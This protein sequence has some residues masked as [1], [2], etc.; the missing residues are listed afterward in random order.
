MT[1][2]SAKEGAELAE[3]GKASRAFLLGPETPKKWRPT[4]NFDA[5]P[6][7]KSLHAIS[8]EFF[9]L[10]AHPVIL[11]SVRA[12]LGNDILVWGVSVLKRQP[13]QVHRWHIDVEHIAWKG[14]S[15]FVGLS[16][17]RPHQSSLKFI[18]GSH[19]FRRGPNY[20]L[21]EGDDVILAQARGADP[22]CAMDYPAMGDGDFIMFD[23][24]MWHA[25]HN[26][27]SET[28]YASIIQYTSPSETVAVP[29]TWNDPIMWANHKPP[30]ILASG[31]DE[32]GRNVLIDRPVHS[33]VKK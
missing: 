21:G 14:V 19:R 9:N 27:T 2:L 26:S 23:G 6:W 29:L 11:E 32:F 15:V 8:P 1:L 3:L 33:P 25:S 22:E 16:G 7:F 31:T 20:E 24:P 13:G 4:P 17:V 5:K 10:A 18:T 30:C 12:V 28:R